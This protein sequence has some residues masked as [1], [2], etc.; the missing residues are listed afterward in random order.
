M[1]QLLL[2]AVT[3]VLTGLLPSPSVSAAS[4]PRGSTLDDPI[5]A[6]GKDLEVRQSQ[7]DDDFLGFKAH[8]VAM[9]QAVPESAR[10]AIEADILDKLIAT[11]L[12]LNRANAEDRANAQRIAEEFIA[13]QIRKTASEESFNRQLRIVGLTPAKFRSKIFEQAVVKSV[14]DREL[15]PKHPV[16]DDAVRKYYDEHPSEFTSPELV[17]FHHILFSGI[18]RTTGRELPE[19]RREAKRKIAEKVLEQARQGE[20]FIR[21]VREF[22]DDEAG[23]ETGGEYTVARTSDDRARALVPEFESAAFSLAP[24]ELSGVVTT[25]FGFHLLKIIEKIPAR[26]IEFAEVEKGLRERLEQE[27]VQKHLEAF[28]Q[29]LRKESEVEI[30]K[31]ARR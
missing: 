20:D 22:S 21:L 8:Q 16:S 3:V 4:S 12:F 18:D 27:E 11:Q 14:I 17:R 24:G 23:R 1:K 28:V 19:E 29:A 31:R 2:V 9:G 25:R 10:A 13:E 7:V 26:T 5:L 15:K 30:V 6:R